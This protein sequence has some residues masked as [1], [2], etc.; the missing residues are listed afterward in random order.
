MLL[1]RLKEKL[2][3]KFFQVFFFKAS[4]YLVTMC[5]EWHHTCRYTMC[6]ESTYQDMWNLLQTLYSEGWSTCNFSVQYEYIVILIIIIV[7]SDVQVCLISFC[8]WQTGISPLHL[9]AKEGHLELCEHLV[10]NGAHPGVTTNVNNNIHWSSKA[11]TF[12]HIVCKGP[13]RRKKCRENHLLWK[14][15]IS[16]TRHCILR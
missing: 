7:K 3:F 16:M 9:A 15:C 11:I 10:E 12:H 5:T 4:W 6:L 14:P 8:F 1:E 2:D 13:R